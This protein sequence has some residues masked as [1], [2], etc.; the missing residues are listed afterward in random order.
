MNRP[1]L[2]IFLPLSL[3]LLLV[4][5]CSQAPRVSFR[6]SWKTVKENGIAGTSETY[7]VTV[8]AQGSQ[9]RID[10]KGPESQS[11]DVYD[12]TTLYHSLTNLNSEPLEPAT[13]EPKSE[14]A[15]E[16]LRFWKRDFSGESSPGGQ[17]A[18]KPTSLY[19]FQENWADNQ[20][21]TQAWVDPETGIVLKKIYTLYSRQ[22]E[23]VLKKGT[24]ECLEIHVG[25]VDPRSFSIP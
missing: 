15:T 20:M 21:T 11:L 25:P 23:M 7:D 13:K 16:P 17:I 24:E 5:G 8:A 1:G 4:A 9:F 19:Q 3:A 12:G 14:N 6:G 2:N 10:S 22:Q 18:G